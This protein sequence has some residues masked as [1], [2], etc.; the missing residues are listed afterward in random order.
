MASRL[1][2]VGASFPDP[3]PVAC[4][5]TWPVSNDE[6]SICASNPSEPEA[7]AAV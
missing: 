1:I 7:Q 5:Q 3:A 2:N 6:V 4:V